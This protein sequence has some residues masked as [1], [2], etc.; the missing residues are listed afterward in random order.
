[1][2]G[3]STTTATSLVGRCVLDAVMSLGVY[4]V[5]C[6]RVVFFTVVA[7]VVSD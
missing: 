3:Q 2:D 5:Y 6:L 1:V 7:F 4:C